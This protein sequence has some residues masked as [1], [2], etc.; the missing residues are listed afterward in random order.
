MKCAPVLIITLNRYEHLKRCIDSLKKSPLAKETDL[1]IGLDYPPNER[2]EEGFKRI[3][4]YLDDGIEGFRNV[5]VVRHT[6]NQ[7]MFRNFTALEEKAYETHDRIIYS[8]D[9]NEF[10]VNFLEYMNRCLA[11]YEHDDTVLAVSGYNY[12]IDTDSF[13]G[14]VYR[15]GTYFAAWGY[16]IWKKK[17]TEM[18]KHLNMDFFT[19]CY[20][21]HRYMRMLEKASRNQYANMIKGMLEYT[22]ELIVE[23]Q[24]REVDLAF[25]LYMAASGKCM[26]FPVESKARNWG[27]D[28]TGEN[29]NEVTHKEGTKITHRNFRFETQEMDNQ[30][31]FSEISEEPVLTQRQINGLLNGYFEISQKEYLRVKAA[32]ILSGVLGM[33]TAIKITKRGK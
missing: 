28:G 29:C 7:G 21:D 15:C 20:K 14:N 26:I 33:K 13:T 19:R 18:R 4:N 27:Y 2:Y 6:V 24:I 30:E 8:E 31:T 9:D 3:S 23:Q 32:R 12:P 25:G 16:G 22:S 11:R 5:I 10:S 17:E 1:Y